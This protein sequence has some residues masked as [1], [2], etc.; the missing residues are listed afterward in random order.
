MANYRDTR[1]DV[2]C[3]AHWQ[4]D[5]RLIPIARHGELLCFAAPS[6]LHHVWSEAPISIEDY[7]IGL[8]LLGYRFQLETRAG[9][10]DVL[11]RKEPDPALP[12]TWEDHAIRIMTAFGPGRNA[13]VK[14]FIHQR[15][16]LA[17]QL[18]DVC[19]RMEGAADEA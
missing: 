14:A 11:F 5:G 7:V 12:P 4:Q 13:E 10:G 1:P 18:G 8:E 9:G 6:F 19:E 17:N 3:L 15:D 2:A 16:I